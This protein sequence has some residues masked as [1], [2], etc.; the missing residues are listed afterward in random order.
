MP[1]AAVAG[2]I[3][4]RPTRVEADVRRLT[5]SMVVKRLNLLTSVPTEFGNKPGFI[6]FSIARCCHVD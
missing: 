1:N 4:T 6:L 3:R 5:F 2:T